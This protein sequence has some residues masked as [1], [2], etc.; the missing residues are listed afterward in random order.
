MLAKEAR[1]CIHN[2]PN[3]KVYLFYEFLGV[4]RRT[5]VPKAQALE[6]IRGVPPNESVP[7]T[8]QA[9]GHVLIH[10]DAAPW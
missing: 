8:E 10:V 5:P 4:L 6:L 1:N 2:A 9:S 7:I 3:G